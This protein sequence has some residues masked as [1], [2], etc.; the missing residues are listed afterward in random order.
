MEWVGR[1][2]N[3]RN[4]TIENKSTFMYNKTVYLYSQISNLCQ[5]VRL[6]FVAL[7]NGGCKYEKKRN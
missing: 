7:I 5:H 1:M 4:Q 6:L 2:N 3:V